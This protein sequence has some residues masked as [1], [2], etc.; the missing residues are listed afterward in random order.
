MSPP[1]LPGKKQTGRW[2]MN[3]NKIKE[4]FLAT[5][6][7]TEPN[8]SRRAIPQMLIFISIPTPNPMKTTFKQKWKM[9]PFSFVTPL[10]FNNVVD[11]VR[12]N[13][14]P[15]RNHQSHPNPNLS[16]R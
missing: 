16:C 12:Y 14:N 9:I 11:R 2:F 10:P 13:P 4:L 5:L 3:I 7:M 6:F 1:P 8:Q 15:L